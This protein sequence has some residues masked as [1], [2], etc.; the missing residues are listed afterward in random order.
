MK[1]DSNGILRFS[2]LVLSA[3]TLA[4]AGGLR[5]A[6]HQTPAEPQV[7]GNAVL[8]GAIQFDVSPALGTLV[9]DAPAQRDVRLMHKPMQPKLQRVHECPTKPGRNGAQRRP[10]GDL[11]CRECHYRPQL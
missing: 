2:A 3:L 9:P 5:A 4:A 10:V 1:K 8:N 6:P 7:L 11:S